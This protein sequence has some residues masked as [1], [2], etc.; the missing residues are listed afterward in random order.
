[1]PSALK[2]TQQQAEDLPPQETPPPPRQDLNFMERLEQLDLPYVLTSQPTKDNKNS[3][4]RPKKK[5]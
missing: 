3:Y 1:M 5:A 2:E 4:G